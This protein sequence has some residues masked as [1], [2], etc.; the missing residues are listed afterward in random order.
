[1]STVQ[2]L[3]QKYG[4]ANSSGNQQAPQQNLLQKLVGSP[5]IPVLGGLLGAAGGTIAGG[6]GIGTG[7]GGFL[8]YGAGAAVR[9]SLKNLLGMN[10][11]AT[12][13][14]FPQD[15]QN[16]AFVGTGAS[17]LSELPMV[18][19]NITNPN[20]AL[21]KLRSYILGD[22]AVPTTE[23]EQGALSKLNANNVYQM[24]PAESQIAARSR[25]GN[26][27]DA[28]NP[29]ETISEGSAT[30]A[31][32]IG[33]PEKTLLNDIYKAL[34]SFEQSNKPFTSSGDM[35]TTSIK[36][37]SNLADRAIRAYMNETIPNSAKTVNDL[38]SKIYGFQSSKLASWL[39]RI[40]LGFGAYRLLPDLIKR[41]QKNESGY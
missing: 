39:P 33:K 8:G 2:E 29:M 31:Q 30:Q 19:K 14:A 22:T 16:A 23:F 35:P 24:A 27:F 4:I 3:D 20:L 9:N 26:F 10:T 12:P 6:P 36:Q 18:L 1:M 34:N 38:M 28:L 25:M 21:G 17:A 37:G 32:Q 13:Q 5:A 7:G 11:Q 40:A 15:A 41:I